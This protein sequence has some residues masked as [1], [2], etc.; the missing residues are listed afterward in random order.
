MTNNPD[1]AFWKQGARRVVGPIPREPFLKFLRAGF[2]DAGM[3]VQGRALDRLIDLAK[4]VPYN[5]TRALCP[6]DDRGVLREDEDG[7][8]IRYR[9]EDPFLAAWLHWTRKAGR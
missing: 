2:E 5:V 1:R 6:L 8:D 4:D 9:P 3:S 7:M